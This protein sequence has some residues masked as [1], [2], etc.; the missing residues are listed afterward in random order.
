MSHLALVLCVWFLKCRVSWSVALTGGTVAATAAPV[1]DLVGVVSG[2]Q[3]SLVVG[4]PSG[5]QTGFFFWLQRAGN[6]QALN[7]AATTTRDAPLFASA[8]VPGRVSSTGGGVGTTYPING[9]V[10]SQAAGS[11]A[12]P[13]TAVLNWPTVGT[14]G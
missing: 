13:N 11:T 9:M 6:C 5:T 3:G 14:S 1:G 7:T 10:V 8:T 4:A 2:S 12:G